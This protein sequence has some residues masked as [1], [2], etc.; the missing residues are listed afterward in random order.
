MTLKKKLIIVVAVVTCLLGSWY[1]H[2][3][4][5]ESRREAAYEA[6][7]ATYQR[8]FPVGTMQDAVKKYLDSQ[9]VEYSQARIG[10]QGAG[11]EVVIGRYP[12]DGLFCKEWTVYIAI[13]FGPDDKLS[14]LH[15][16]RTG[17]CL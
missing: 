9:K 10:N 15:L 6:I 1:I 12:V 3:K 14:N 11:F 5:A 8:G 4:I 7:L 16:L 13:M 17:T 2:S